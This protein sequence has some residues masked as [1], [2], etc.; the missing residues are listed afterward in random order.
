MNLKNFAFVLLALPVW[1]YT[2]N[3]AEPSFAPEK[4]HQE[5]SRLIGEILRSSPFQPIQ[6]DDEFSQKVYKNYLEALDY[7]RSYFLDADIRE[8]DQYKLR[9]D[10]DLK[11]GNNEAAYLMYNRF[12]KRMGER[13]K[14]TYSLLKD[15]FDFSQNDS[16][17]VKREE[18]AWCQNNQEM[19]ALW[20]KKIKYEMVGMRVSGKAWKDASEIVRKR[21]ENLEKQLSKTQS[22]DIYSYYMNAVS[23]VV[24][25]HTNYFSAKQG[26]DFKI[27]TSQAL[28]GIGATLQTENDYTKI[29][30]LTK[31]GPAERSKKLKVGDR[32]VWVAQGMDG[33]IVDVVGWRIDDVVGKIR[34]P[35]GSIVRLGI[36]SANEPSNSTPHIVI[37]ERDKIKL[38]EQTAKGE[39]QEIKQDG[40]KY[41]IAVITLP[42][43]Y[44]DY[45]GAQKG[46]KDFSSS[47]RDVKRL[48]EKYKK[49]GLDAVVLDLRNN[50]GG[51]LLEAINLSGLFISKGPVVQVKN[52][53]GSLQVEED[54]DPSVTWSGPLA[55]LVN[56]FSAS[57]SEILAA[58]IQDYRRGLI[59]GENT[60]GKGTVQNVVDLNQFMH[61]REN[62]VGQLK[63]T[64]AKFYRVNGSSTQLKGVQPDISFPSI[65]EDKEYGEE[66]SPYALAWDQISSSNYQALDM[67][68]TI[69]VALRKKH[70]ERMRK[71][72]E[73]NYLLDDVINSRSYRMKLYASVNEKQ[74]KEEQDAQ[75]KKNKEREEARKKLLDKEG[76]DS[77]KYD[78]V[79]KETENI[80][81][82][83]INILLVV[84]K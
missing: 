26:D 30:E 57:A 7:N 24:D 50:G 54:H 14:Y 34:G 66:A 82:D 47:T 65:Y 71:N 15:S 36:L 20:L 51:S 32:I 38:E 1:A 79:L 19:D 41:R 69:K 52:A 6:I 74:L 17:M 45:S 12:L 18:A 22:E 68:E 16:F 81:L 49:D 42:A 31:G 75:S 48:I 56:R 76:E 29:R 64:I 2:Q 78:L 37:I 80:L 44:Y 55:V 83:Y 43:F 72:T 25:P 67:P 46:E 35:K 9:L 27:N 33:E 73:Y 4:Q 11:A 63:L 58:A 70:D 8:F 59:I 53:D 23:E 62:R 40:K 10:D 84:K 5:L 13:I 61:Q 21:Y 3:Q 77:S 39:V 28:E 60:F